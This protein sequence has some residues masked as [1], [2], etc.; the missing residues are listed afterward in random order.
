MFSLPIVGQPK[1]NFR[2]TSSQG[3]DKLAF[4]KAWNRTRA[5]LLSARFHTMT[6]TTCQQ[7]MLRCNVSKSVKHCDLIPRERWAY[8][9]CI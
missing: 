7:I 3:E 1:R 9:T 4:V 8:T 2:T 5:V 6:T